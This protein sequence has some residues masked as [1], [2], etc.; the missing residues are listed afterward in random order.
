MLPGVSIN[1]SAEQLNAIPEG[2]RSPAVRYWSPAPVRLQNSAWSQ[3]LKIP[4]LGMSR[5]SI[6]L[7]GA[8]PAGAT[9]ECVA[10]Y[11]IYRLL[12]G[13]PPQ[14]LAKGVVSPPYDI[15]VI[16]GEYRCKEIAIQAATADAATTGVIRPVDLTYSVLV[17]V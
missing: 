10:R 8:I 2:P 7:T 16:D 4:M 3:V 6:V 17:L 1:P 11:R 9:T 15:A 14:L 12:D 5:V 13:V